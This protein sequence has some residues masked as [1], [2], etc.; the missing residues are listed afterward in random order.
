MSYSLKPHVFATNANGYAVFLDVKRDEYFCL[1]PEEAIHINNI[2]INSPTCYDL[3]NPSTNHVN[4][5]KTLKKLVEFK[6]IDKSHDRKIATNKQSFYAAINDISDAQIDGP[7][8]LS[9]NDFY[10]FFSSYVS[11]LINLK[12]RNFYSMFRR[13]D[14]NKW[15]NFIAL[16]DEGLLTH[17]VHKF[18]S[19]R[20]FF[21]TA[22]DHCFF[23]C[24][25]LMIFLRKSG[26]RPKWYFG[27]QMNPFQAHCWVQVSNTIVSDYLD[28]TVRFAPILAI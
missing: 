15:C 8:Q 17:T 13:L 18:R 26:F 3:N 22:Y 9:A 28:R 14:E 23:D 25:V 19:I 7:P 6:L 10:L 16:D 1:P 21:Y 5:E 4:I 11:A 12:L 24:A 27:V 20:P 2:I